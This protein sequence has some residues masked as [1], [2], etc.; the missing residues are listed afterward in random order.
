MTF[1]DAFKK[2]DEALSFSCRPEIVRYKKGQIIDE[3]KSVK[4]N[5]EQVEKSQ[6]DYT[7]A[8]A[9][10]NRKKNQ[11]LQES[12][13]EMCE[14]IKQEIGI[15]ITTESALRIW[16]QSWEEGRSV[17]LCSVKNRLMDNIDFVQAILEKEVMGAKQ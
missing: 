16:R 5:R 3:D 17:G 14:L 11:L 2:L 4:W 1:D 10:L 8:V 6:N 9:E 7:L 15:Q 13:E 12:R